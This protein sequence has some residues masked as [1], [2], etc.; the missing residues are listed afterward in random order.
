MFGK[1][2]NSKLI[3]KVIR[4]NDEAAYAEKQGDLI[5]V[6]SCID[7]ALEMAGGI[8]EYQLLNWIVECNYTRYHFLYDPDVDKQESRDIFIYLRNIVKNNVSE[9]QFKIIKTQYALLLIDLMSLILEGKSSELF[10]EILE[11]AVALSKDNEIETQIRE[12]LKIMAYGFAASYHLKL[13]NYAV[14]IHYGTIILEQVE[15]DDEIS[16]FKLFFLNQLMFSYALCG[17][18]N[19]A[20]DLGRFLYIKYLKN[21]IQTED[22]D[23]IHRMFQGYTVTL[24][25]K[26]EHRL[27]FHVLKKAFE[28]GIMED[29]AEETYLSNLYFS[30]IDLAQKCKVTLNDKIYKKAELLLKKRR[31]SNDFRSAYITEKSGLDLVSVMFSKLCKGNYIDYLNKAYDRYMKEECPEW[32]FVFYLPQMV[33]LLRE[34]GEL[35]EETK[36]KNCGR[37]LMTQ[38][39]KHIQQC[40]YYIDNDRMLEA[41]I[42]AECAFVFAYS[43]LLKFTPDEIRFEYILNY[44]NL[45]PTIV[46][47]RDKQIADNT[48][49]CDVLTEVNNVKDTIA[50]MSSGL[51]SQA[52]NRETIEELKS[53][54]TELGNLFSV[55]YGKRNKIPYYSID[56]FIRNVPNHSIVLDMFF[57]KS[58]L[59][60]QPIEDIKVYYEYDMLEC[61]VLIKED[62]ITLRCHK[63]EN[64]AELMDILED[65]LKTVQDSHRKYKKKAEDIYKKLFG[66]CM[67]D[68]KGIETIY[69]CP[70][71]VDANIP[72]DV[73]FL[74]NPKLQGCK[75]VYMQ[76]VRELFY[77]SESSELTDICIVGNPS[78]SLEDSYSDEIIS[79]KRGMHL[80]PLPFSE[81]EARSIANIYGKECYIGKKA[82]KNC[83]RPG[84]RMF[85]I[86]THGFS[87]REDIENVWYSSALSFAGIV[88]WM[89]S[90]IEQ[91][92]Y[93]NG[94]LTADEISR[95]NLNGTE[96]VVLSAC[97]SGN[98]LFYGLNHIAGLHIAFAAAGVNYIVSSL[99]EVDDFATA[100]LMQL[101]SEGWSSGKS[102]EESLMKAKEKMRNM[103]V[104]EIYYYITGNDA[105]K[106]IPNEILDELL[107]MDSERKIFSSPYYWAGFV[108]YQN[109]LND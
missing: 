1:K 63:N 36:V 8:K 91:D 83:I 64:V 38:L 37:H 30:F 108:C 70:H 58:D 67:D 59:Y 90:G 109:M 87:E 89:D 92:T 7:R 84:Y 16:T 106:S 74:Q 24:S 5:K 28:K 48:E 21:E 68:V 17:Q 13:G 42:N 72:F 34:Y 20:E 9:E 79:G 49:L 88:D 61:F 77:R 31:E 103:T 43:S 45:L 60:L 85:H 104:G 62:G 39:Y 44:K 71:K 93:G 25:M 78:Y 95:M 40:Q 105:I 56:E 2:K 27:A 81:Y 96:L 35:E 15:F 51:F 101:F 97:N 94:V 107:S 3:N 26:G 80:I 12:Y 6:L 102:V 23:E 69:I 47:Y 19:H 11:E 50:Q 82:V 98:S 53:R 14:A 99:W 100:V 76:T 55:K 66:N 41:L 4:L 10:E 46:K 33:M 18:L 32:E 29:F 75:T 65:F 57:S 22:M 54:L 52:A 86:A 73:I